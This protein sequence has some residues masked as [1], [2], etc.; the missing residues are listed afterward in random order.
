VHRLKARIVAVPDVGSLHHHYE[1]RAAWPWLGASI[2]VVVLNVV[3]A[4]DV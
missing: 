2:Q 1:R 3:R 4:E